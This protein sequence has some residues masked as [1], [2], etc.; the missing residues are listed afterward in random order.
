MDQDM[1]E[2]KKKVFNYA[3]IFVAVMIVF[4]S[5]WF[6]REKNKNVVPYNEYPAG[7]ILLVRNSHIYPY[8]T[9]IAIYKDGLVKK[10]RVIDQASNTNKPNEHYEDVKKLSSDQVKRLQELIGDVSEQ[11]VESGDN[12]YGIFM[13]IDG[14]SSLEDAG[15]FDISFVERLN[16]FINSLNV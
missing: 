16:S 9:M 7:N 3:L 6:Y 14:D 4:V 13:N 1:Q 10:S 5:I 12:Y 11:R 15:N 8:K 2:L